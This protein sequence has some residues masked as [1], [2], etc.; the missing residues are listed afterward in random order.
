MDHDDEVGEY[1]AQRAI[2]VAAWKKEMAE[3]NSNPPA[4]GQQRR[5]KGDK[6][7]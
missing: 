6:G 7:K 3:Q 5:K 4:R 1:E 2:E